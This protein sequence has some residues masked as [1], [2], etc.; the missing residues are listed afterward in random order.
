MQKLADK[1]NDAMGDLLDEVMGRLIEFCENEFRRLTA[2]ATSG[3]GVPIND[4][5]LDASR[6]ES[7]VATRKYRFTRGA[8]VNVG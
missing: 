5:L 7:E 8:M 1:K 3:M 6:P 2:N 4:P